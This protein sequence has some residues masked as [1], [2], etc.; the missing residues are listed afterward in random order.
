MM[1]PDEIDD[2]HRADVKLVTSVLADESLRARLREVTS[3]KDLYD[4]LI[5]GAETTCQANCA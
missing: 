3:S 1:V 4:A 5:D 2:S